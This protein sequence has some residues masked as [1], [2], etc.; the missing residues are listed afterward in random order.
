MSKTLSILVFLMAP[1]IVC[2]ESQKTCSKS[3][4]CSGGHCCIYGKCVE[5]FRL[6]CNLCFSDLSCKNGCC[7]NFKCEPESSYKCIEKSRCS[8]NSDCD[9]SCCKHNKC[10]ATI[11][12]C[13]MLNVFDKSK[14]SYSNDC[15]SSRHGSCCVNRHCAVCTQGKYIKPF[16]QTYT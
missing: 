5:Y 13:L 6:G 1:L 9:S 14:C 3:D 7:I 11:A 15:Y 8:T 12:P 2:L 4:D 16:C 10:Q